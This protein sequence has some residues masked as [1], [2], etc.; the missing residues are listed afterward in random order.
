MHV[1]ENKD[2]DNKFITYRN[3]TFATDLG[4]KYNCSN[5]LIKNN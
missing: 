3:Y 2:I 1:K 5:I 4:N